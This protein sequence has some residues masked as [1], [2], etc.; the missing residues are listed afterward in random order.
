MVVVLSVNP[1]NICGDV[2]TLGRGCD[3]DL[4]GT[5]LQMLAST[6]AINKH[7]G[8]LHSETN[9]HQTDPARDYDAQR[10]PQQHKSSALDSTTLPF[11]ELG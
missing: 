10:A 5:S 6:W 2:S 7:T 1:N 4:L 8:T 11:L 9:P 3:D